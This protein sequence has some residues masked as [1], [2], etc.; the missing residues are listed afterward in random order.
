MELH[1][2]A[3]GDA[4]I[5][6]KHHR[7]QHIAGQ[8]RRDRTILDAY[9]IERLHNVFRRITHYHHNTQRFEASLMSGALNAQLARL[10]K[11]EFGN[12][13]LGKVGAH[14][15]FA[16]VTVAE[17]LLCDSKEISVGDLV[18]LGERVGKVALCAASAR[19]LFLYVRV[20]NFLGRVSDH[21]VRVQG[22]AK[23]I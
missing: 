8:L 1:I 7:M 12:T 17:R 19:A 23:Y 11:K 20:C 3:Y 9:I 10:K 2:A 13:L 21:S 15:A 5:K 4:L 22:W 18:L 14:P 16:D 6:P